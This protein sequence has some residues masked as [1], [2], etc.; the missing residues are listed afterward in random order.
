[1]TLLV[2]FALLGYCF[3]LTRFSKWPIEFAPFFVISSCIV[4]LYGLAY[5]GYLKSGAESI[6]ITGGLLFILSPCFLLTDKQSL[7]T[8]Y[9]TPGFVISLL[10]LT[11][12][13]S[14]A[15]HV[16]FA[17]FDEFTQW[18]PHD[19]LIDIN[20]GF[21]QATDAAIH[22]SY[23][24]AGALFH[25]LFFRLTGFNEGVAYVAQSLLIMAPLAILVAGFEWSSWKKVFIFYSFL[26]FVLLVLK[27]QIGPIDSLY[28]DSAVGIYF[29]M[30]MVA[31]L[32]SNKT[33]S[34]IL[35]LIPAMIAMT[36][37]KQKLFPLVIMI[38]LII[39][40]DQLVNRD[41]RNRFSTI[42]AIM[43]LPVASYLA[44]LSW[45][46]HLNAMHTKIEWAL[47]LTMTKLHDIFFAPVGSIPH[48]IIIN[49]CLALTST[50]LFL[51]FIFIINAITARIKK[52]NMSFFLIHIVL[53]LGLIGYISGLLLMYLFSFGAYEAIKHASMQRYLDI[54]YLAWTLVTLYF[55]FDALHFFKRKYSPVIEYLLVFLFMAGFAGLLFIHA[56]RQR[57]YYHQLYSVWTLRQPTIKIGNAVK[58]FTDSH[59]KILTVWQSS[60]GFLR[61][62]MI[63]ELTPRPPALHACSAYGSPYTKN[64][65][66]TCDI[67]VKKFA[68]Q[69]SQFD[70][71]L[72]AYTDQHFWSQ[73]G[74]LFPTH[75]KPLVTY[76]IC[77]K[78][79]FNSFGQPGC[80]MKNHPAYLFKVINNHGRITL[81]SINA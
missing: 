42:V 11:L 5:V 4:L 7:S 54:Y 48:T 68:A 35:Y 61:A 80:I 78:K 34:A 58:K 10:F 19:K 28:M 52:Q 40:I 65:V 50:G 37:F 60:D 38:T 47:P 41:T 36:L 1:M 30:S 20:N 77:L 75:A 64:D 14:L 73:Y 56:M 74:A 63:Y 46:H 12:F 6:L 62:M 69:L 29:G 26:L 16:H 57:N 45:H 71:L 18:G 15:Y 9:F 51:L 70:Y 76:S 17:G 72:L 44:T 32:K 53:F 24:P 21:I 59:A 49:Y 43:L 23:P 27:V 8:K 33:V 55:L 81:E 13:L 66:W 25:Y 31:Y 3:T 39:A 67:S 2:C 22:K 79:T